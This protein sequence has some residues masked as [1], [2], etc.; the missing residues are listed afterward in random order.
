MK[1]GFTFATITTTAII[2]VII[3]ASFKQ[4]EVC[5]WLLSSKDLTITRVYAFIVLWTFIV[6]IIREVD[7]VDGVINDVIIG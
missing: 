2:K 1:I 5:Y 4:L 7:A 3:V 6:I